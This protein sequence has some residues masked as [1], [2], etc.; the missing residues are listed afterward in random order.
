MQDNK[1][2]P[3]YSKKSKPNKQVN[4]KKVIIFLKKA[5][6]TILAIS[7]WIELARPFIKKQETTTKALE[8]KDTLPPI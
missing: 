1:P 6:P 8:N 2:T 4:M 7:A 5:I 3:Y